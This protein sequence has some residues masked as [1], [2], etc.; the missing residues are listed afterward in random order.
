MTG[1]VKLMAVSLVVMGLSHTLTR[2]RL[3]EPLRRLA[4]GKDTWLGYLVSCPYCASHWIAFMLVPLTGAYYVDVV[5][6]L[7]P[8]TGL[9]RWFFSSVLVAMLAAFFRVIFYFVD[10]SQGLVR[11]RQ[12]TEE[13]EAKTHAETRRA[14]RDQLDGSTSPPGGVEAARTEPTREPNESIGKSGEHH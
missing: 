6:G 7:G 14:L 4:G 11:R 12:R 2:E 9:L 10:E 8:L 13:E 1:L 3:F 5:A